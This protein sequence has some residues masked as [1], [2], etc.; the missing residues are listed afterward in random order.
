[1]FHAAIV[2]S[3]L[4]QYTV[5]T[6]A[7]PANDLPSLA[8]NNANSLFP[9]PN[10]VLSQPTK[11]A[12]GVISYPVDA[13][14]ITLLITPIPNQKIAR[15]D[16]VM[17]L[18]DSREY[19][20]FH[21]KQ[22]GNSRLSGSDSPF[23]SANIPNPPTVNCVLE[24]K[25]GGPLKELTYKFLGDAVQGLMDYTFYPYSASVDSVTFEVSHKL[26]GVLGSGSL[27]ATQSKN[28]TSTAKAR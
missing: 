8:I 22:K 16:L 5:Y 15:N 13:T 4:L 2:L 9:D 3:L 14:S 27:E 28:T 21:I 17:V 20:K 7:A 18:Y 10:S 1:M 23:S 25:S 11:N 6:F 19:L 26:W 12:S 24:V